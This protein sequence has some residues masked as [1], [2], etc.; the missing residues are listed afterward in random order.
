M[1]L[2]E[3]IAQELR[4]KP[5]NI[6]DATSRESHRRWDSFAH[7]QLVVVL[8]D[9]YGVKFSNADIEGMTS[10]GKIREALQAKGVTA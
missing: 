9:T 7:V 1:K 3:L 5:A 4:D 10:V 2:E 8:E 6:T